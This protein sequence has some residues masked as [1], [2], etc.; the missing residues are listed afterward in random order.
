MC[1]RVRLQPSMVLIV[2]TIEHW[3]QFGG[4]RDAPS[5][6]GH[7]HRLDRANGARP[8]AVGASL[9]HPLFRRNVL[10]MGSLVDLRQRRVAHGVIG[11][12]SARPDR[13]GLQRRTSVWVV[14]AAGYARGTAHATSSGRAAG[15]AAS[16]SKA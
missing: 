7:H 10:P 12:T 9:L 6:V 13:Y 16:G 4:E 14:L 3:L 5:D 8:R 11:A 15:I 2:H 1:V